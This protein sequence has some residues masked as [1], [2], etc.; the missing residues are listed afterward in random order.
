MS[1][2]HNKRVTAATGASRAATKDDLR[3]RTC[4]HANEEQVRC[5]F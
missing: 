3:D 5:L 2:D 1:N 4:D